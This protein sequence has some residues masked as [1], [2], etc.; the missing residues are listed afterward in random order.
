MR[1]LDLMLI[2]SN[3]NFRVDL[4]CDHELHFT[5]VSGLKGGKKKLGALLYWQSL[6][7][8]FQT[9]VSRRLPSGM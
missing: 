1:E 8:E 4:N 9:N 3:I 6:V 2:Q 7:A 5:P